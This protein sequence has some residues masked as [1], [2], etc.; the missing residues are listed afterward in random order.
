M[1]LTGQKF[2]K[3]NTIEKMCHKIDEHII[4]VNVIVVKK[5]VVSHSNLKRHVQQLKS[6]G[7]LR[8]EKVIR[9]S[10]F[11]HGCS[12]YSKTKEYRAWIGYENIV[13]IIQII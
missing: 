7:C 12:S 9:L 3:L 6:C 5:V 13:V 11:K 2:G 1:D 4:N 10:N 8:K